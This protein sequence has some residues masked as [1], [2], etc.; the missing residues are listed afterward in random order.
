MRA[1]MAIVLCLYANDYAIAKKYVRCEMLVLIAS[2]FHSS[3]IVMVLIPFFTLLRF[4]KLTLFV[5]AG[6]FGVGLF[7]QQSFGDIIEMFIFNERMAQK[8][9]HY[10][11]DSDLSAQTANIRGILNI[12]IVNVMYVCLA[13]VSTRKRRSKEDMKGLESY[14]VTGMIFA[15][16][17]IPVSLFYRFVH[18]YQIYF[19]ILIAEYIVGGIRYKQ[20]AFM[21]MNQV[22][23][24]AWIFPFFFLILW[25]YM[26]RVPN[27]HELRNYNRYYPYSTVIDQTVDRDRER[28]FNEYNAGGIPYN[29]Y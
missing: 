28:L 26:S 21:K 15:V 3:A 16:L 10:A 2:L 23:M 14:A 27:S 9:D 17:S 13:I 20:G 5:L 1:S 8:A 24:P 6:M 29:L 25:S 7:V 18:F 22:T 4:N 11:F 12:L 19:I